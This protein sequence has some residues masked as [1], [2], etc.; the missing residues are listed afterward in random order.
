MQ[1]FVSTYKPK[2]FEQFAKHYNITKT[3]TKEVI[4][5]FVDDRNAKESDFDFGKYDFINKIYKVSDIVRYGE[6]KFSDCE[7]YNGIMTFYPITFKNQI[8]PYLAEEHSISKSMILDDDIFYVKPLDEFFEH[9]IV[10]KRDTMKADAKMLSILQ[11]IFPDVEVSKLNERN[12]INS[13]SF[14]YSYD[15]KLLPD[16]KAMYNS[17]ETLDYLS[18]SYRRSMKLGKPRLAGMAS[19]IEQYFYGCH[20]LKE[21][22]KIVQF[23][24]AVNLVSA[25]DSINS[26][27]KIKTLKNAY[28]FVMR[29]KFPF[30]EHFSNSIHRNLNGE[31]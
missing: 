1:V 14:I 30:M 4:N 12:L 21:S 5:V 15:E 7:C 25:S 20:L 22:R 3:E 2:M 19:I 23:E 11:C 29:D 13:G 31:S 8:F 10:V 16:I 6:K 27:M 26:T 28:H 17:L 18:E 24:S 9:D